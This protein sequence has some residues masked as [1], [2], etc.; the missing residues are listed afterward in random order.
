MYTGMPRRA[1]S[2]LSAAQSSYPERP[3][4]AA[5]A[6]TRSGRIWRASVSPSSAERAAVT[7]KSSP[8][9]VIAKAFWIVTLSSAIKMR[10]PMTF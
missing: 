4:I 2:A 8:T 9:S 7:A 5:S 6:I 3:G 10:F 1:A